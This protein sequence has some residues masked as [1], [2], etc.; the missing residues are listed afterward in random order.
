MA[1]IVINPAE[2]K[3]QGWDTSGNVPAEGTIFE[4]VKSATPQPDTNYTVLGFVN[5]SIT[6]ASVKTTTGFE[7][8]FDYSFDADVLPAFWVFC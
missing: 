4:I 5:D 2:D 1:N 3:L 8:F 6:S 7:V